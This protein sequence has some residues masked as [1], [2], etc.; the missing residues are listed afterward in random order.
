MYLHPLIHTELIRQRQRG[1]SRLPLRGDRISRSRRG[2]QTAAVVGALLVATIATLALTSGAL[3]ATAKKPS[4]SGTAPSWRVVQDG[5]GKITIRIGG[6]IVYVYYPAP[7]QPLI[8]SNTAAN[9]DCVNY[10]VNCTDEQ[11]CQ[12][13]GVNCDRI[14]NTGTDTPAVEQDRSAGDSSAAPPADDTLA[15]S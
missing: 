1:L 14:A 8:S 7:A 9:D 15:D 13:W 4:R 12:L 11:N 6:R 5:T 3:A 10:Q 2:K